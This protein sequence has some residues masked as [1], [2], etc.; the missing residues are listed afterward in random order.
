M[1]QGQSGVDANRDGND[2][3]DRRARTRCLACWPSRLDRLADRSRPERDL[4]LVRPGARHGEHQ[5]S[6]VTEVL[7]EPDRPRPLGEVVDRVELQV[8]VIEFLGPVLG[9]LLQLYSDDGDAGPGRRLDLADSRV[10]GDLRLDLPGHQ[11]LDFLGTRPRPDACGDRHPDRDVGI[12]ALRHPEIAVYAPQQGPDQEDPGDVAG[13]GEESG[14]VVGG[15]DDL[16]VA[17]VVTHARTYGM[18]LTASPS[19]RRAAPVTTT[20]SP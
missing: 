13:L 18:T 14:C 7:D 16:G 3:T 1:P 20:D 11:L 15:A 5:G 10:F 2:H 19:L 8:D 6:G 17:L 9:P 12:L 4:H